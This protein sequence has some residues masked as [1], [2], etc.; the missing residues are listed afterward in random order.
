MQRTNVPTVM[1]PETFQATLEAARAG[2]EG[3]LDALFEAFYPRVQRMVHRAL[4]RDLRVSRPWLLA[5]FSTG[6]VVQDVFRS[7]LTDIG[8]FQGSTEDAFAG[9]LAMVARNRLTDAIRFHQAAQRD[10][11][12]TQ[13]AVE[14]ID[15]ASSQ[16][17]PATGAGSVEELAAFAKA[18]EAFPDREQLLLRARL[19]QGATFQDLADQLGFSSKFA[20]RRAFYAAQA[21]LAIRLRIGMSPDGEGPEKDSAPRS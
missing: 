7:V 20:A 4:S 17:G 15:A 16:E 14:R 3:A 12:R 10:G 21:Q 18:L 9:Y 1:S 11:R 19:E 6:D 2:N 5:R 8:A 13:A